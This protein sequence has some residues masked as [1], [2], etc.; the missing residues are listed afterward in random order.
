M[1][2]LILPAPAGYREVRAPGGWPQRAYRRMDGLVVIVSANVERDGR[3]WLHVSLSRAS[4][5]PSWSDLRAVKNAFIG[6]E[7]MAVQVLPREA[8]YVN[9]HPFTLHL[10]HCQDTDPVPDFRV[11]APGL[12]KTL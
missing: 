1:T 3:T 9:L 7:K 5:L 6:P 8:E 4:K 11:D 10:W 12:G 2:D